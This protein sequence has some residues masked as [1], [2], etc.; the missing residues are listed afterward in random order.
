MLAIEDRP[1]PLAIEDRPR[2][3]ESFDDMMSFAER[4]ERR[5]ASCRQFECSNPMN[6][7]NLF[8]EDCTRNTM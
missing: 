6:D 4:M 3:L 8:D 5:K 7:D 2:S 1:R